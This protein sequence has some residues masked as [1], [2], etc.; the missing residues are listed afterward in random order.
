MV[1]GLP[2]LG[3]MEKLHLPTLRIIPVKTRP[4]EQEGEN[5]GFELRSKR[6]TV[7]EGHKRNLEA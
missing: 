4:V 5:V 7:A 1:E 3:K 2:D 6:M